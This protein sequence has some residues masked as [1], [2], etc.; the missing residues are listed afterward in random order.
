M[1]L[2]TVAIVGRPNVGKSSLLNSLAGKMISIVDPTAGV[3]RDRISTPVPVGEGY[4]ELVDTGGFGI[5]D[6]DN[7][8][9]H[10]E[11]QI[12]YAMATAELVLFV[13]D[14]QEGLHVLDQEVAALLRKRNRPTLLVANKCD[15]AQQE[16]QATVFNALGF[17]EPIAISA[18]QQLGRVDLLDRIAREL[19]DTLI[20]GHLPEEPMKIAIVGKR[21]AGK[22]SFINALAGEQRVIVSETPGTTRDSVDVRFR[23]G[24][25]EFIAID[26]AGIRKQSKFRDQLEFYGY[27]RAQRS[28]RRADVVLLFVDATEPLGQVDK[29]LARYI[30]EQFKP[31]VIVINK[32]DLAAGKATQED[33]KTYLDEM[34]P[35]LAYAPISFS[36]AKEGVNLHATV[37]LAEQLHAQASERVT[38]GQLNQ[39]I[40]QILALRGPSHKRGTKPPKLYYATQVATQPPTIACFVNAV[41]SFDPTYQRFFLNELRARLPF[42]EVPIRLL[43]R[44]RRQR[45]AEA[46]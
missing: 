20:P 41:E 29:Q 25:R 5:E 34:L 11:S 36:S 8:T 43:F 9:E 4:A 12:R 46:G 44:P 1:A 14:A 10:V 19:G 42:A 13:V 18:V 6:P 3:T 17:G 21:N 26:T 30:L 27:H 37:A 16:A 38:T 15:N 45:P 24:Q 31:V 23:I 28:I 7:L 33:Y 32:W 22:S 35:H 39:A 2:P 40:E